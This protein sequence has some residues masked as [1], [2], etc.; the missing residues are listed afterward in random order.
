VWC[1]IA[2]LPLGAATEADY[3]KDRW[4]ARPSAGPRPFWSNWAPAGSRIRG[5][6]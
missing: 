2:P 4:W 3:L 6:A 1:G 5:G